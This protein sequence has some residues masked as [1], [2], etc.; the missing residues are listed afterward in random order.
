MKKLTTGDNIVSSQF[1]ESIQKK[2]PFMD[3]ATFEE[4]YQNKAVFRFDIPESERLTFNGS[5]VGRFITE[6]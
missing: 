1:P 3:F 2:Y 5:R 4:Y 6:L